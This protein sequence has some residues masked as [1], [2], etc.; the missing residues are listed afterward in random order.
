MCDLLYQLLAADYQ[1]CEEVDFVV[2]PSAH[3][4]IEVFDY[5]LHFH[6]LKDFGS[7]R[8]NGSLIGY[9]P[10]SQHI[11]ASFE[12]PQQASYVL[13]SR[14]GKSTVTPIWL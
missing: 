5:K 8:V 2:T 9:G 7:V 12:P 13:D 3:T 10:Y 4:Y 6:Q 1:D 11:G 14:R